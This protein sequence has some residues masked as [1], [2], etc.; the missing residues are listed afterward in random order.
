MLRALGEECRG[1]SCVGKKPNVKMTPFLTSGKDTE[2]SV[3][4]LK[5]ELAHLRQLG[6]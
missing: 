1:D 6:K 2:F 4:D 3:S 5:M